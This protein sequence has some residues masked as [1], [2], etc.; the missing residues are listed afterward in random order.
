[1]LDHEDGADE[2]F[3]GNGS[4]ESSG[5]GKEHVNQRMLTLVN[6]ALMNSLH[7]TSNISPPVKQLKTD[8]SDL[9]SWG[10]GWRYLIT[11]LASHLQVGR[12]DMDSG[13]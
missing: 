9:Q 11:P 1:M 2:D 5:D 8:L 4:T 7:S 6:I 3:P 13:K 10:G 12:T